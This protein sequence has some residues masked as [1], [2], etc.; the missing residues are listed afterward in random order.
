MSS[1]TLITKEIVDNSI[2]GMSVISYITLELAEKK[3]IN[4]VNGQDKID[5]LCGYFSC[6][7]SH[8]KGY[9]EG[10]ELGNH[11]LKRD[12]TSI[13]HEV[14]TKFLKLAA[15]KAL[16][17]SY[18][19][20]ILNGMSNYCVQDFS[21]GYGA[22]KA[23]ELIRDAWLEVASEEVHFTFINRMMNPVD[24]S[25]ENCPW[26]VGTINTDVF[27]KLYEASLLLTSD[28]PS[29]FLSF[30]D[31]YGVAKSVSENHIVEKLRSELDNDLYTNIYD[32]L[33]A[34]ILE[35]DDLRINLDREGIWFTQ[36]LPN[37]DIELTGIKMDFTF[38]KQQMIDIVL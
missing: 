26:L 29:A 25:I 38:I 14:I 35:Q 3:L 30:D 18:L 27:R 9:L 16:E 19:T 2:K 23:N 20:T 32:H 37:S 28:F 7:D 4:L 36:K 21:R 13:R 22:Q 17:E 11:L 15:T 5:T 33:N 12:K 31:E 8:I 24:K 1:R 34:N 10:A 6:V